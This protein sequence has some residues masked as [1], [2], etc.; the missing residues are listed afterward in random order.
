[1]QIMQIMLVL[2]EQ[3]GR[4]YVHVDSAPRNAS[5][6]LE[7]L[8]FNAGLISSRT[9]HFLPH[10]VKQEAIDWF[11]QTDELPAHVAGSS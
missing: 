2:R 1:M 4:M 3:F 7:F 8:E 11:R 10:V 9:N 5:S 6:L